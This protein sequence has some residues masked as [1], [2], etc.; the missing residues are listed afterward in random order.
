M[1][2]LEAYAVNVMPQDIARFIGCS[3]TQTDKIESERKDFLTF[4]QEMY[5]IGIMFTSQVM[6]WDFYK[7]SEIIF[8][9]TDGLRFAHLDMD[10]EEKA[11]TI[12]WLE[13]IKRIFDS[14]A[15]PRNYDEFGGQQ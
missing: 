14:Q 2:V 4:L 10:D 15:N 11:Y 9:D 6:A 8:N 13:D 3:I 5:R 12:G 1:D 7:L